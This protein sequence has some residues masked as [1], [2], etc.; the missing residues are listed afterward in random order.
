MASIAP[1]HLQ[2]PL[3]VLV[4]GATGGS[5]RATVEALLDQG[6]RVTAF[7][8]H[9][10]RLPLRHERLVCINGDAMRPQDIDAA[11]RGH[12]A[13]CVTLGIADDALRVRLTGRANTALDVRSAG[14]RHVIDA[15][16]RHGV[17]RLVVQTSF[18]VGE[19]R[20]KLPWT[21]QVI[22][23]LL[24]KPQIAD[25]E[26]QEAAVRASG[27]DW[28]LIQPVNLTDGAGNGELLASP[29]G[30]RRSLK[31]SRILVGRALADALRN[32]AWLQR[33][34]TLSEA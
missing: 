5:G 14:T 29:A 2:P 15:M 21:T 31:V 13:V 32:V 4:V 25:T 22:F 16:R 12:G 20:G 18:G 7:S 19:T 23:A 33:S 9:A 27:L 30:A 6:H 10:D 3:R 8:R 17:R 24:L 28:T 1:T 11:V 34:V 26:R